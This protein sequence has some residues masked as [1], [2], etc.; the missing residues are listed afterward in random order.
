MELADCSGHT[1]YR[2]PGEELTGAARQWQVSSW[3]GKSDD[4]AAGQ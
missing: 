4:G 2:Q 3:S 1:Q